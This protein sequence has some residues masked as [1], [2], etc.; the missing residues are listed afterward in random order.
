MICN[1]KGHYRVTNVIAMPEATRRRLWCE[2]CGRI[3]YSIEQLYVLEVPV[4]PS[5]TR[6]TKQ[7]KQQQG[8]VR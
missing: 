8:G 3:S 6:G 7:K 2:R 1:C 5:L 4:R